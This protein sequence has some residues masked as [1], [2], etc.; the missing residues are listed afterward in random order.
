MYCSKFCLAQLG[1]CFNGVMQ[2]ALIFTDLDGTLL[3]DRYD[4]PGAADA[5]DRVH[6]MGALVVPISSKTHAEMLFVA[7]VPAR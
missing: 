5:L 7:T 4:L 3:D 2:Q 6:E 1:L